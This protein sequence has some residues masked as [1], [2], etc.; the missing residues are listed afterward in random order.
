MNIQGML[1]ISAC[2][3]LET[4]EWILITFGIGSP[5][6]RLSGKF[7]FHYYDSYFTWSSELYQFSY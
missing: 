4:T 2:Y 6:K 1:F 7:N 3:I 5:Q